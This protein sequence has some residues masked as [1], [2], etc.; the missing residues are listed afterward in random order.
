[1]ST[2]V[3]FPNLARNLPVAEENLDDF[4]DMDTSDPCSSLVNS[5]GAG[6]CLKKSAALFLL[7]MKERYKLTQVTLDF[8]SKSNF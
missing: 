7:Q 8:A 3:H 2:S 6:N 1:M 5:E 4:N